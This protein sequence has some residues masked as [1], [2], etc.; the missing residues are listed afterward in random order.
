M[1]P[2]IA[3]PVTAAEQLWILMLPSMPL[4]VNH[5]KHHLLQLIC[6]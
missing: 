1:L 2:A 5:E 4:L 6:R 3:L